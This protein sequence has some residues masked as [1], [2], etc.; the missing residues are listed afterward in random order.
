[1][2]IHLLTVSDRITYKKSAMTETLST[3]KVRLSLRP[4][5][6]GLPL[7]VSLPVVLEKMAD[8]RWQMTDG[9]RRGIHALSVGQYIV[10]QDT[11]ANFF[12]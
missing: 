8:G 11:M 6:A 9:Q 12:Q 7:V 5:G 10:N 2:F 4:L 1:M 3:R